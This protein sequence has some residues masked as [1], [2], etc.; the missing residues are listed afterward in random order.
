M[1]R[2]LSIFSALPVAAVGLSLAG[3]GSGGSDTTAGQ[4]LTPEQYSQLLRKEQQ[5]ENKAH[6]AV[7]ESFQAKSAAGI[8]QALSAFAEDQEARAEELS[9]A[10]PPD[11]AKPAQAKLERAFTETASAIN[12]LIPEVENAGSAKEA[13]SILQKAEGPQQAGRELDAALAELKKLGYTSG[14]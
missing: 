10:T 14:S 2:R 3:C 9:S 6:R 4:A 1:L 12:H 11:N 7:E 8:S 13:L 5:L